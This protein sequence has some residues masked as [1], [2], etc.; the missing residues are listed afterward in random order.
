MNFQ[1][2]I[3]LTKFLPY[4]T[5]PPALSV[6]HL[7][8]FT[9]NRN[10]RKKIFFFLLSS[11]SVTVFLLFPPSPN[12]NYTKIQPTNKTKTKNLDSMHTSHTFQP[13]FVVCRSHINTGQIWCSAFDA[14][15][16]GSGQLPSAVAALQYEWSARIALLW[17]GC[18]NESIGN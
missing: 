15:W 13:R 9:S 11:H 16:N 1:L 3:S 5:M 17:I 10:Y 4:A 12:L 14:M 8:N 18:D 2:H 6:S 7:H